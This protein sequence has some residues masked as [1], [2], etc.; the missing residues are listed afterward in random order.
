MGIKTKI[1]SGEPENVEQ[2][3][4]KWLDTGEL[5]N[6]PGSALFPAHVRVLQSESTDFLGRRMITITFI[7]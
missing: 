3:I 2:A 4:Q 7:Y 6:R 5:Y 1:F